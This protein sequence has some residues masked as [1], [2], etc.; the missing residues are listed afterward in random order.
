MKFLLR[1]V[2][3]LLFAMAGLSFWFGG[4]AISEFA[5]TE[6]ILAEI[7]GIGLAAL[8]GGLGALAKT[9][10]ERFEAEE[11]DRAATSEAESLKK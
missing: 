7:E 11:E 4:R 6:R 9:A 8:C 5:K 2:A 10:A 1:G 3:W